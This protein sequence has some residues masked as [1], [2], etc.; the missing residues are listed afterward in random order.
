MMAL[1]LRLLVF[2]LLYGRCRSINN[3]TLAEVKEA[4]VS[5]RRVEREEEGDSV[6]Q[7]EQGDGQV[8]EKRWHEAGKTTEG[9]LL[10]FEKKHKKQIFILHLLLL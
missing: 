4:C 6:R 5:G 10:E 2:S 8:E 3:A 9:V 1:C 7:R